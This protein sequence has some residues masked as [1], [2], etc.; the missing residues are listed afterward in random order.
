MATALPEGFAAG[1]A[2]VFDTPVFD[3]PVF[4]TPVFDTP[5]SRCLGA[6]APHKPA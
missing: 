2:P 4:D 1:V 3:T 6:T 5:R